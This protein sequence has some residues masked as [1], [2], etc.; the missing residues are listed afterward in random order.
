MAR[1]KPRNSSPPTAQE[2]EDWRTACQQNWRKAEDQRIVEKL[3]TERQ[4]EYNKETP[5][6]T[7]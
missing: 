5:G 6:F 7:R 1:P 3:L 4:Q 2:L